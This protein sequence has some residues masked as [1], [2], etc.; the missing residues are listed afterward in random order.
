MK[1]SADRRELRLR[2]VAT[3]PERNLVL[4]EQAS[5]K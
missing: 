1:K 3:N 4:D 2:Q 5:R